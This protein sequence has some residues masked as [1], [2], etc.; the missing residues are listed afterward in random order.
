MKVYCA[1]DTTYGIYTVVRENFLKKVPVIKFCKRKFCD[2]IRKQAFCEFNFA[3]CAQ[4]F[5]ICVYAFTHPVN[6]RTE[7]FLLWLVA[8]EQQL[9]LKAA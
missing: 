1:T 7:V 9:R 3:I 8:L 5:R 2:F 6:Q 4:T